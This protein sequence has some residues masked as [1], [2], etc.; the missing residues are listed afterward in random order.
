[1]LGLKR[2]A[3]NV[4]RREWSPGRQKDGMRVPQG[5]SLS[6]HLNKLGGIDLLQLRVAISRPGNKHPAVM[7][8]NIQTAGVG[9]LAA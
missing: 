4:P 5:L 8:S 7:E 3:K 9:G 2:A 1:M 6:L